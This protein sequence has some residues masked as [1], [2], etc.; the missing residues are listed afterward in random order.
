MQSNRHLLSPE[1]QAILTEEDAVSPANSKRPIDSGWAFA[2][3]EKENDSGRL[4]DQVVGQS[5]TNDGFSGNLDIAISR[6]A[7]QRR[8]SACADQASNQQA[9]ASS[10][11]TTDQHSEAGTTAY[12]CRRAFTLATLGPRQVSRV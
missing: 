2:S 4:N 1:I 9:N 6:Q 10:G 7:T 11:Y 8:S 12:D 5:E 3:F